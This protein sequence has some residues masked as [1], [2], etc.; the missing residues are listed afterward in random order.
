MK[1][2]KLICFSIFVPVLILLGFSHL[3]PRQIRKFQRILFGEF[4]LV[5][6][7]E[8]IQKRDPVTNNLV[9]SAETI[10]IHTTDKGMKLVEAETLSGA[11]Y[12]MG[13]VHGHD[14][15]WQL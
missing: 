4:A 12:G 15:M 5:I 9:V 7:D 3:E 6:R 10:E 14:R 2:S 11:F 1:L 13:F 8:I